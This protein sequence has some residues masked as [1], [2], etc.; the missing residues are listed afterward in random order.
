MLLSNVGMGARFCTYY[1][2]TAPNDQTGNL[3]SN[4]N[5]SLGS[6]LVLDPADKSP[7]LG[8]IKPGST[9]SSLETNMF[10]SPVFPHKVSSTDYLLVRSAK[11]KL[12]IR[13]I[14][15][16]NAVGQQVCWLV[17]EKNLFC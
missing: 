7:F 14:D 9:Q 12:S 8:E 5:R 17:F 16:I 11:G 13:R 4:K 2:K 10:R 1:Q 3:F 6:L 15:K